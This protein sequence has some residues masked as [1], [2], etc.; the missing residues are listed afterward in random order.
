MTIDVRSNGEGV[1]FWNAE[2]E[3]LAANPSAELAVPDNHPKPP[4]PPARGKF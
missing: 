2:L 4:P 1:E 3:T